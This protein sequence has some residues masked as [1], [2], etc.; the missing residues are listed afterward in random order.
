[1][2]FNETATDNP[3]STAQ[4][5]GG[6]VDDVRKLVRQE[7]DLARQ[8]LKQQWERAKTAVGSLLIG[9][10]LLIFASFLLSFMLVYILHDLAGVPT[11]GSFGIVG[12][13]LAAVGG[14]LLALAKQR[15]SSIQIPPPLTT[16]TLKEN[17][18]WMKNQM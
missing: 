13:V 8:E 12:G 7:V 1:M 17:V 15:A 10:S 9:V 4:L 3:P 2:P 16:E 11:W 5:V 6:I 14:F 18:Q